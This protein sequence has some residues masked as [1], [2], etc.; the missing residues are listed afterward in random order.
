MGMWSGLGR[1]AG[2]GAARGGVRAVE[3]GTVA[4]REAM[5]LM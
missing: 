4:V 3:E 5:V 2:A 1:G